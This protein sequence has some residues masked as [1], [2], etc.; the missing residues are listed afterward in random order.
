MKIVQHAV[1]TLVLLLC[2][3]AWSQKGLTPGEIAVGSCS[4][5]QGPAGALG[6]ETVLGAKAY[7]N[8]VNE[9]G[10]VNGRKLKLVSYDDSYEPEKTIACVNKLLQEDEVFSL[11]FFVGT[12][13]GA[14]AAPMAETHKVP[15]VG[16]FTGA[17]LLRNP[18]KHYVVNVRASYYN[19]AR[20]MVDN[21]VGVVGAKKIAVFYQQD[22]FGQA[23]LEGVKIALSAHGMSPVALGTFERN[24]LEVQPGIDKIKPSHPD[25]VIM[26]GPY[27]PVAEFV[28]RVRAEKWDSLLLTVSFVGTEAFAKTAGVDGNGVVITQVV[29]PP[30]RTDLPLVKQYHEALRKYFPSAAPSF[31]SL[32]G[33][34]DAAV[35]VEGFKRAGRDLTRDKFI[36]ALETMQNQDIGIGMTVNYSSTAH[37]AFSQLYPTVIRG[38]VAVPLK[39]WAALKH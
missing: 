36:E 35:M 12:P 20:T 1:L 9:H 14:K 15:I 37:Q 13:T 11:G 16:F 22:A 26:V 31:V 3:P 27:A 2:L 23:V 10:G 30:S 39:D 33:F 28:K 32:E 25:A 8:L 21:L 7:F 34:V 6:S 29:P 19:E 5:L 24:T 18:V 4:A 38:G 17:E